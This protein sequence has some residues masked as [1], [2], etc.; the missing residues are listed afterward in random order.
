MKQFTQLMN[1]IK[2]NDE[3]VMAALADQD[4]N[5][6][7][8]N[9]V[10]YVDKDDVTETKSI[11]KKMGQDYKVKPQQKGKT[12]LEFFK[13]KHP[14]ILKDMSLVDHSSTRP[15]MGEISTERVRGSFASLPD[16]EGIA[17]ENPFHLEGDL[18]THTLMV[19]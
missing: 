2:H 10:V 12:V 16:L 6:T 5:S 8:K 13:E 1:E 15:D 14:D 17:K 19:L 18:L 7:V 4:I 11:I 9:G 3:Y